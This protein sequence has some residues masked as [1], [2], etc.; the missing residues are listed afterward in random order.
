MTKQESA[1]LRAFLAVYVKIV[2]KEVKESD[3]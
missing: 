2:V 3:K 1:K